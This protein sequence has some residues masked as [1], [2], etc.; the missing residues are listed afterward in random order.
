MIRHEGVRLHLQDMG[1][2]DNLID[3]D[4]SLDKSSDPPTNLDRG[5]AVRVV[6]HRRPVLT[7][8]AGHRALTW[9]LRT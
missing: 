4:A 3:R 6:R 2:L 9:T 8:D 1:Q 7:L 5:P